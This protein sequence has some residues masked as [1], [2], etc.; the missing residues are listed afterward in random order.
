MEWL[1][2]TITAAAHAVVIFFEPIVWLFKGVM[3]LSKVFD[4][5]QFPE[6]LEFDDEYKSC[7]GQE[8]P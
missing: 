8:D 4:P 7:N 1:I 2:L 3:F 6:Q 5:N